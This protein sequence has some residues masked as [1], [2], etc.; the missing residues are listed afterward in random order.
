MN[1]TIYKKMIIGFAFVIALM[2]A[3]NVYVLMELDE[4]SK[5]SRITL[6]ADVLSIDL[7]KQLE[8]HLYD[9]DRYAQ[10]T[11]VS[12]QDNMYY[13]LFVDYVRK[14]NETCDSLYANQ[15]T[16]ETRSLVDR[17]KEGNTW[18]VSTVMNERERF[19]QPGRK[20]G[21]EQIPGLVDTLQN[22]HAQ[23]AQLIRANQLSISKSMANVGA[24]ITQSSNVVLTLALSAVVLAIVVAFTITRS[25]TKSI[26]VLIRGTQEVARGSFEPIHVK[27]HDEIAQLAAAFNDMSAQLKKINDMKS[28]M[29]QHISHELRT[30]LQAMLS[31]HYLL[32][33]ERVGPIN[34]EQQRLL[35]SMR[36]SIDKLSRFSNQFLDLAK[37]EAGMMEF[38]LE[39]ADIMAIVQPAVDDARLIA[40]RKNITVS[41]A[42]SHA[43]QVMVDEEKIAQVVSNLVGNAIKY[44]EKGG[45]V[46]VS[47][48]ECKLGARIMV[49][50]NGAGIAPEDLPKIFTKFYRAKNTAKTGTK[51]TG[52]GL[53]LVKAVTEGHG[54]RVYVTSE[55]GAGTTFTVELPAV[56]GQRGDGDTGR[57]KMA[58]AVS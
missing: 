4:V 47:V 38:H 3:F 58:G 41:L 33:E 11:L 19:S 50:D 53:A 27:S 17:I 57:N 36:H 13:T 34:E 12:I 31:A 42:A 44:T 16:G 56:K 9:E 10:N 6:T 22:L 15:Q 35:V 26:N 29:M 40:E 8:T 49:R 2:V 1:L 30:P 24:T 14:F 46:D 37:I 39:P 32:A 28:E 45:H 43:P 7:A 51:G 20:R 5:R 55:V 48:D 21:P 25:I 54:G 18:F 52:V 23:I